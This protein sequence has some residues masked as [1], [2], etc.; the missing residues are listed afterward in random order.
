M[1]ILVLFQD[2]FLHHFSCPEVGTASAHVGVARVKKIQYAKQKRSKWQWRGKD[3]F[4]TFLLAADD[5]IT[6]K[7]Q[8]PR[9]NPRF[10]LI[11]VS[12]L[13]S[14]TYKTQKKKNSAPQH[15][16]KIQMF[17]LGCEA[18]Y[19][20]YTCVYWNTRLHLFS[21]PLSLGRV[22]KKD[23][24]EWQMICAQYVRSQ[25]SFSVLFVPCLSDITVCTQSHRQLHIAVVVLT[26]SV[27]LILAGTW[28]N[29]YLFSFFL[30]T[31]RKKNESEFDREHI[32]KIS[33]LHF[34]V[35]KSSFCSNHLPVRS[36]YK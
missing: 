5:V 7:F 34:F 1:I 16:S 3:L 32:G 26:F 30:Y 18:E 2:V 19:F 6:W 22:S 27:W 8:L 31:V 20:I 29:R 36:V 17:R 10:P 14:D 28:Q 35:G 24:Y 23:C 12:S 11:R 15:I 21:S 33:N 25:V 4:L 13:I 9:F